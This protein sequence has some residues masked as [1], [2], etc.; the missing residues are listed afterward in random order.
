MLVV[1]VANA[2]T[3]SGIV[4]FRGNPPVSTV[5]LSGD[6]YC[7]KANGGPRMNS[8]AVVVNPNL[9]LRNVFIYIKSGLPP[10][11]YPA[12]ADK[13][14]ITQKGCRYIPHVIG[15]MVNQ[16]LVISNDDPTLH[17]IHAISSEGAGFNLAE[18]MKGM[19][20]TRS[21]EKPEIMVR[22]KCDVHK[23]MSAYVGVLDHP[24]FAVTDEHG[25]FTIPDVPP[26]TYEIGTWHEKYGTQTM[27][28]T[29]G[30]GETK[31]IDFTYNTE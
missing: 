24:Y 8:E 19:S 13:V 9:T 1:P 20:Q 18:P 17:N 31:K 28:V 12:S 26:G 7:I 27:K 14:F 6:Q 22:L 25:A 23:W 3:L 21:F 5:E 2:G 29:I 16:Q 30:P 11:Q 15:M 10:K 4:H